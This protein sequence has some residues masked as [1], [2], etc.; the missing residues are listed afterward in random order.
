MTI[1]NAESFFAWDVLSWLFVAMVLA[2][3]IVL[4]D[5]FLAKSKNTNKNNSSEKKLQIGSFL[6]FLIFIE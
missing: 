3:I 1:N 6:Y 5:L 2:I 4:V